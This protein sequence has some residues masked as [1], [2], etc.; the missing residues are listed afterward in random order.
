VPHLKKKQTSARYYA[1]NSLLYGM[2]ILSDVNASF[3]AY[4]SITNCGDR[5]VIHHLEFNISIIFSEI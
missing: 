4:I 3:Y 5:T 1:D 2:T